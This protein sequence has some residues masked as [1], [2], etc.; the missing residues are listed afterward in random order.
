VTFALKHSSCL[1]AASHVRTKPAVL[2]TAQGLYRSKRA[3]AMESSS[4]N[5]E[6]ARLVSTCGQSAMRAD[7]R[8]GLA[9]RPVRPVIRIGRAFTPVAAR[10]SKRERP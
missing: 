2:M 8:K 9:E 4:Q 6:V 7:A 3:A 1:S 5:V 10:V